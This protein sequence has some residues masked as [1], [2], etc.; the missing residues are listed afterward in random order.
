MPAE[1]V[2]VFN[3]KLDTVIEGYVEAELEVDTILP[4]HAS[5]TPCV[6]HRQD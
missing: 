3:D 5:L 6:R 1:V 4:Q 2:T